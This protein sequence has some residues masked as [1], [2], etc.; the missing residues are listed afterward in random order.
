MAV[1][2]SI[3]LLADSNINYIEKNIDIAG[4]IFASVVSAI[5]TAIIVGSIFKRFFFK[6]REIGRHLSSEGIEKVR[7]GK[8]GINMKDWNTL[9]NLDRKYWVQ[10]AFDK[11]F[12]RGRGFVPR[13]LDMCFLTGMGFLIKQSDLIIDLLKKGVSINVLLA[14]PRGQFK[15]EMYESCR[16]IEELNSVHK[17][18]QE[19]LVAYYTGVVLN[20]RNA[21]GFLER[22]FA[23]LE[24]YN[25][26]DALAGNDR[27]KV[28]NAVRNKI[29]N[30]D[31][32]HIYQVNYVKL[33][34]LEYMA[35]ADADPKSL[36]G[37]VTLS[38][39]T[40]EYRVPII[41]LSVQDKKKTVGSTYDKLVWTNLCAPT[42]EAENSV[43]LYCRGTD[44]NDGFAAAMEKTIDYLKSIS[45][46]VL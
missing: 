44:E 1:N 41:L 28:Q 20:N 7:I 21:K 2:T 11:I 9:L 37:T 10:R 42:Q 32:E 16:S 17:Q 18:V 24:N 6:Q 3:L 35:K 14:T 13:Q 5:I 40:D 27:E 29:V 36:H 43:R 4:S 46:K 15:N 38:Y 26:K 12:R 25:C 8:S 39:Y 31:G 30:G 34:L 33:K 19:E 23:M 22:A 45:E